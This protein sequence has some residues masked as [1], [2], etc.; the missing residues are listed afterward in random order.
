MQFRGP[1]IQK[2]THQTEALPGSLVYPRSDL[3]LSNMTR[4][5]HAGFVRLDMTPAFVRGRLPS[6]LSPGDI[7][8]NHRT[9]ASRIFSLLPRSPR[10]EVQTRLTPPSGL[11]FP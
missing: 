6:F 1:F 8:S 4:I 9:K 10:P 3:R 11:C 2:F 7:F 5:L